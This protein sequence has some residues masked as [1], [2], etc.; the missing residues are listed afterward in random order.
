M[1]LALL[2]PEEFNFFENSVHAERIPLIFGII[3]E[4]DR[5]QAHRQHVD[6]SYGNELV[7]QVIFHMPASTL[8]NRAFL[9]DWGFGPALKSVLAEEVA[10]A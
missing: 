8:E 7:L 9:I 6:H 1:A 3:E 10:V 4:V 5:R 2:L